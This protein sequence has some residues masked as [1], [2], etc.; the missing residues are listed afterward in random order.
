MF[1]SWPALRMARYTPATMPAC[2]LNAARA[3]VDDSDVRRVV[4]ADEHS[5][6]EVFAVIG[7]AGERGTE[8]TEGH[9]SHRH[10]TWR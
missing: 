2:D 10:E 5:S 1:L 4:G 7:P 9:E 6:T 3:Q 8:A